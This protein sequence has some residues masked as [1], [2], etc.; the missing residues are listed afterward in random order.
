MKPNDSTS[1]KSYI[2]N[3]DLMIQSESN[4]SALEKLIKLL[5][6]DHVVDFRIQSGIQAGQLIEQTLQKPEPGK[7]VS[8][9]AKLQTK[10]QPSVPAGEQKKPG[11]DKPAA[12]DKS[13]AAKPE[14]AKDGTGSGKPDKNGEMDPQVVKRIRS[15]IAANQLIRLNVNKGRGVKL[16]VPCRILNMDESAQM[17]TVYH[18]D[19]KQVYT[20]G[21]NE[22][23]DFIQ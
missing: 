12:A 7:A 13:E 5:N 3:V 23:D 22:I 17:I 16:S 2:F 1:A 15:F 4:A 6:Q 10:A 9:P 11:T 21:L 20:F 8:I 19:E 14:A 18:V